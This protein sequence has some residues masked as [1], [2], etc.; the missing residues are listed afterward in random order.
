MARITRTW[1]TINKHQIVHPDGILE[2]L[3][4]CKWIPS[5]SVMRIMRRVYNFNR[6]KL[7]FINSPPNNQQFKLYPVCT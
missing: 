4:I 6:K 7:K 3:Q 1:L 5:T 2:N